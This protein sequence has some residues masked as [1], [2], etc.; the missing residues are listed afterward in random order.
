MFLVVLRMTDPWDRK[1]G[2]DCETCKEMLALRA[3]RKAKA[4]A[5]DVASVDQSETKAQDVASVDQS[6]TETSGESNK[7]PPKRDRGEAETGM[8]SD[9]KKIKEGANKKDD[10]DDG[11]Q[12]GT[13]LH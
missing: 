10:N 8:K 1:L 2:V 6:E 13:S 12:A 9:C 3:E 11:A 4:Q 7:K 5:D